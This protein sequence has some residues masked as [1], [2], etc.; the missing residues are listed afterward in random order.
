MDFND[1]VNI[2]CGPNSIGKTTIL[3]CIGHCFG[4][5]ET[6]VLKRNAKSQTGEISIFL[7][8]K[9]VTDTKYKG[10]P[11]SIKINTFTPEED[12]RPVTLCNDSN[13]IIFLKTNRGF[14]Y[15]NLDYVK[16]DNTHTWIDCANQ[17][18]SGVSIL[19]A[20]EWFINRAVFENMPDSITETER[21]NLNLAKSCFSVL[22]QEYS[23]SRILANSLDIMVNTPQGE[24]YFEYLS[25]GFKSSLYILFGIIKEIELRFKNEQRINA[26]DFDGIIL[27]DEIEVHMHPEWQTKI[28]KVLTD[29][30]PK[31]Q[32]F[33]TTHSPHVIQTAEPQQIISLELSDKKEVSQ[34]EL[35]A[36]EYGFK[37]W[38]IEE[39]LK[40]VMGMP[41]LR[42]EQFEAQ[43]SKFEQALDDNTLNQAKEA[44]EVL[45][46]MIHPNNPTRKLLEIQMAGMDEGGSDD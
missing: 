6:K 7:D 41:V 38:T 20:K 24:I 34:R 10:N 29:I 22:S 19:E 17:I 1:N 28:V 2:I 31:A 5:N 39:I 8:P 18:E 4:V 35:P 42:S 26:H 43:I 30:F 9:H 21:N 25:S 44:F 32:F 14:G 15:Q 37:G 11:Y 36:S 23:F 45:S 27:I 46:K 12:D 33:M 13:K 40:D 16:K 3:E